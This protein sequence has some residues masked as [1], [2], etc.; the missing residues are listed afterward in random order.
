MLFPRRYCK[1]HR[2]ANAPANQSWISPDRNVA[3]QEDRLN[4]VAAKKYH[5]M[6]LFTVLS[7]KPEKLLFTRA[8]T[9]H[10]DVPL[11]VGLGGMSV[12]G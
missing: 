6:L 7:I 8:G 4:W 2:R 5:Q 3:W 10:G 11:I 12:A 1:A 9:S